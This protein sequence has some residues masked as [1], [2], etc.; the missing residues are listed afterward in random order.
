MFYFVAIMR[1]LSFILVFSCF[2]TF[3]FAQDST[4]DSYGV[5]SKYLEDQFYIGLAYNA[6]LDKP[7]DV[8]QRNLSYNLQLGFIKDIPINAKRNFGFGLG[9][10]YA[11]NSYYSNI[12]AEETETA[13]NYR[14][15]VASDSLNRSK[16][17][18]HAIEF[19]LEIR[20]RTSNAI[21]YKFWRI[22]G[23]VKAAYLFSRRSKFV[24]ENS[25]TNT[26]FRNTDILQ[27]QYGL[28]LSVGYN[29]WNMSLYYGLNPLLE[30]TA[31]LND[32]TIDFQQLRIGIIFYIL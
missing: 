10:G 1:K 15:S 17:E 4:T 28:T 12:I 6:L 30:D 31:T 3:L 27:W 2:C 32:E 22:Y 24:S 5:D 23:G 14:L 7:A 18:T 25:V 13:I 26:S 19:P 16:F 11:T 21:D 20:W 29:T 8:I 9:V